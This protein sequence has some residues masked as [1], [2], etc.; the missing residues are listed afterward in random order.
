MSPISKEEHAEAYRQLL[1]QRQ[2]TR[3]QASEEERQAS[4]EA[5]ERLL[6][7]PAY[8]PSQQ[9]QSAGK[10]EWIRVF[11]ERAAAK[12]GLPLETF[13][14][15][16]LE[17]ER[18]ELV[19]RVRS[20]FEQAQPDQANGKTAMIHVRLPAEEKH[21]IETAARLTEV[22]VSEL[23]RRAATGEAHA[24]LAEYEEEVV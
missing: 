20:G 19:E 15:P 17:P 7:E 2:E 12:R 9:T 14:E 24:I 1:A 3:V 16:P 4:V 6:G 11:K 10:D 21:T 22:T 5:A 23:V 13:P 8:R 18:D